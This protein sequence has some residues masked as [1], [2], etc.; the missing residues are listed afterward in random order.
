MR[1]GLEFTKN[2]A[3]NGIIG[4]KYNYYTYMWINSIASLNN[5]SS[6]YDSIDDPYWYRTEFIEE[7]DNVYDDEDN[8]LAFMLSLIM[9]DDIYCEAAYTFF[10]YAYIENDDYGDN[11]EMK[12]FLTEKLKKYINNN[13]KGKH[14]NFNVGM[15]YLYGIGVEKTKEKQ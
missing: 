5:S 15:V 9:S 8:A 14:K 13:P 12:K 6:S 7:D 10:Q 3:H 4:A 1:Q 11:K 2:A